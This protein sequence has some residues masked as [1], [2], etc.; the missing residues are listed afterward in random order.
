MDSTRNDLPPHEQAFAWPYEAVRQQDWQQA[1]SRWAILRRSYPNHPG[2]WSQGARAEIHCGNF[3]EADRLLEHAQGAFPDHA[4]GFLF[5]AES[6][7]GRKENR[8]A[9]S[10][11]EDAQARFPES[12]ETWL[13]A[14]KIT[15]KLGNLQLALDY[16][17]RARALSPNNVEGFVQHAD[18]LV[19]VRDWDKALEA[20]EYV[21]ENFPQSPAGYQRG[22]EAC[23]MAGKPR[24][25]RRILLER[26]FG[27]DP[28]ESREA[29]FLPPPLAATHSMRYLSLIW[30]KALF[31]L[32]AE[33]SRS[34][35][36][37]GW[38]IIEPVL[39]MAVYQMVFA[40]LLNRG[41]ED[42]PVFLL[43]GL[44]PWMWVAKSVSGGSGSI[45]AGQNLML[46]VGVP[47]VIFPAVAVLKATLKHAPVLLLLFVFLWIMGYPPTA[48]WWVLPPLILVQALLTTA[49]TFAV[50]A[51]IPFVRDLNHL[52]TTGLTLLMFLSGVFYDYRTIGPD[53]QDVFLM[54]P[55]AFLLKCYREIL[56]QGQVPDLSNLGLWGCAGFGACILMALVFRRLRYAYPRVVLR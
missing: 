36:S 56:M 55:M 28:G 15:A 31:G 9:K 43:S 19:E 48:A 37:Y 5:A 3:E 26:Q 44:I 49:L 52:V 42:Y 21:R 54:N 7:L 24:M 39:H 47:P 23:R 1:A 40:V 8:L 53:W 13:T 10:V 35:L 20:W 14:A 16:N 45:L 32:R 25:A 30:T 38:W 11:L 2:T 6:A 29:E 27:L 50:A 12:F 22:A 4:Q 18:L 51:I 34:F 17:A 46:Q 41:G 33:V